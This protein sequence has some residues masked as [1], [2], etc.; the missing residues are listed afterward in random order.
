MGQYDCSSCSF[1]C[2]KSRNSWVS[3]Q[4]YFLLSFEQ[5]GELSKL[6]LPFTFTVHTLKHYSLLFQ[7]VEGL[8]DDF[9]DPQAPRYRAAHVFF[10]DSEYQQTATKYIWSIYKL[11]VYQSIWGFLEHGC[12]LLVF[13]IFS[14]GAKDW[15]SFPSH[16]VCMVKTCWRHFVKYWEAP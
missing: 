14:K 13:V 7:S 4:Y 2:R 1:K 10:T 8:I 9:R 5:S 3:I 15:F 11:K 6:S 16:H 12:F